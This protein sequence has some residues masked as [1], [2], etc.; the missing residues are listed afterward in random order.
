MCVGIFA[1]LS[2][3]RVESVVVSGFSL[4]SSSFFNT[5]SRY[6]RW[7][8]SPREPAFL[9]ST[10]C[11]PSTYLSLSFDLTSTSSISFF[12]FSLV[13]SVCVDSLP[14]C[15]L[16]CTFGRNQ[17]EPLD[18]TSFLTYFVSV[19]WIN[20]WV[21]NTLYSLR[22]QQHSLY[23]IRKSCQHF[24]PMW[25]VGN[26]P[27]IPDRVHVPLFRS[28]GNSADQSSIRSIA[29]SAPLVLHW[30]YSFSKNRHT[31]R[32]WKVLIFEKDALVL[33]YH[34]FLVLRGLVLCYVLVTSSVFNLRVF[35]VSFLFVSCPLLS[36]CIPYS[37]HFTIL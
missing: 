37:G 31:V 18:L 22:I 7:Q 14:F 33:K 30:R 26:A 16:S 28:F 10:T 20:T 15:S 24:S 2:M 34:V 4:V 17:V 23:W 11:T 12:P 35:P 9:V 21:I 8:L 1:L 27:M 36:E 29:P 6:L 19:H 3:Y 25:V 32:S 5:L 13:C